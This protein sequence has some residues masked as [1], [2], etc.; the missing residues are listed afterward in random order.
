[1]TSLAALMLALHHQDIET[2]DCPSA[3]R[4]LS[5]PQLFYPIAAERFLAPAALHV[6]IQYQQ[7]IWKI[8]WAIG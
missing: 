5:T 4:I 2:P 7:A 6:A 8:I 3:I 1:V